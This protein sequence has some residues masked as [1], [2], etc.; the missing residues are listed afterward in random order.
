MTSKERERTHGVVGRRFLALVMAAACSGLCFAQEQTMTIDRALDTGV[1][2]LVKHLPRGMK[3]VVPY[4][5]A[6]DD[7][8]GRYLREKLLLRLIFD[9]AFIVVKQDRVDLERIAARLGYRLTGLV[10]DEI[11][12]SIGRH[13]DAQLVITGEFNRYKEGYYRLTIKALQMETADPLYQWQVENI[14]YG[15]E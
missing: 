5:N 12:R 13:L 15:E 10:S 8:M 9:S 4:I 14:Q 11:I 6:P 2:F 1:A 7:L 3:V